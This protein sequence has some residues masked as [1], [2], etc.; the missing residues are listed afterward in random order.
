MYRSRSRGQRRAPSL[1][2]KLKLDKGRPRSSG[3]GRGA[4]DPHIADDIGP[5]T[6]I[7]DRSSRQ[8]WT[9]LRELAEA[10]VIVLTVGPVW[11]SALGASG[12]S[13]SASCRMVVG[14]GEFLFWIPDAD[15]QCLLKCRWC[16]R[17]CTG[18]ELPRSAAA[19]GCGPCLLHRPARRLACFLWSF[20]NRG[21][22]G[23]LPRVRRLC[24]LWGGIRMRVRMCSQGRRAS[25]DLDTGS[26]ADDRS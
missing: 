4:P 14:A 12:I 1:H 26:G 6:G 13:L 25:Q 19:T 11:P 5:A 20:Y 17:T 15:C 7:S 21:L 3:P 16:N 9:R 22:A 24:L 23:R 2:W 18:T 8:V 10:R